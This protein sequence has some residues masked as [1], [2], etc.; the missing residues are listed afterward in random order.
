MTLFCSLYNSCLLYTSQEASRLGISTS[1]KG[2][3]ATQEAIQ[4]VWIKNIRNSLDNIG[5]ITSSVVDK[6]IEQ[7]Y[8]MVIGLK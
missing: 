5:V 3:R 4:D 6:D 7:F 1:A 2:L 8:N